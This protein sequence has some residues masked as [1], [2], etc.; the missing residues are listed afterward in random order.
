MAPAGDVSITA[1]KIDI[2][3]ARETRQSTSAQQ[4]KQSGIS[5]TLINPV[6]EAALSAKGTAASRHAS[7]RTRRK[8][9]KV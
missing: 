6:L 7:N 2:A 1:K 8:N 5:V 3:E 9:N 4:F